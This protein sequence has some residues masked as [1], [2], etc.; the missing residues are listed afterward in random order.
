ERHRSLRTVFD[1]SWQLATTTEQQAMRRLAVFPGSF[2]PLAAR[3]VADVDIVT[4][5]ALLDK[6]LLQNKGAGRVMWHPLLHQ[7]A[8]ERHAANPGEA[9]WVWQRYV[10]YY[11]HMLSRQIGRASCR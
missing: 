1:Y 3:Q 7:Y 8:R 4:I 5:R 6:S 11:I 2:S 9:E 10:L